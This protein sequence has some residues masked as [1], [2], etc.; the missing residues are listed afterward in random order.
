MNKQ[1]VTQ[2]AWPG[3]LAVVMGIYVYWATQNPLISSRPSVVSKYGVPDPVSSPGVNTLHSRIW[4]DPLRPAY[5]HWKQLPHGEREERYKGVLDDAANQVCQRAL[6]SPIMSVFHERGITPGSGPARQ[7][8]DMRD[9]YASLVKQGSLLCLAVYVPGEPYAEDQERRTRF[10]YAVESALADSEYRLEYSRR[11]SYI[12]PKVYIRAPGGWQER[13]IV[14]PLKLY[15]SGSSPP[16]NPKHILVLWIN[17]TEIGQRPLLALHRILH[18]IFC[19]IEPKYWQQQ[20]DVAI[21]GPDGSDVLAAMDKELEKEVDKK[22]DVRPKVCNAD[23]WKIAK[24]D[25]NDNLQHGFSPLTD[26]A[27]IRPTPIFAPAA[28]ATLELDNL[29]AATDFKLFRVIGTDEMLIEKLRDE[30]QERQAFSGKVVLITESDT[31][32]GQ[33]FVEK[34]P[35]VLQSDDQNSTALVISKDQLLTFTM[36]RG[37]DGKVPGDDGDPKPPMPVT[38]LEP[39]GLELPTD[40]TE[41]RPEGRSQFDYLRRLG[42]QIRDRVQYERVSAIGVVSTD[43]YDKLLV[44]RALRP[45]FPDAVYFTTDMDAIYT[46]PNERPYTRGLVVASHFGLSLTEELQRHAPQFRDSYQTSTFLATRLAIRNATRNLSQGAANC[47]S[48]DQGIALLDRWL[49]DYQPKENQIPALSYIVGRRSVRRLSDTAANGA[50]FHASQ[51]PKPTGGHLSLA[52]F[53]AFAM[54]VCVIGLTCSGTKLPHTGHA[55][56]QLTSQSGSPLVVGAC[57]GLLAAGFLLFVVVLA[58]SYF[59][60]ELV[61]PLGAHSTWT[62]NLLYVL[63]GIVAAA[64]L[65]Y[66]SLLAPIQYAAALQASPWQDI[67]CQLL[68]DPRSAQQPAQLTPGRFQPLLYGGL[69]AGVTGVAACAILFFGFTWQFTWVGVSSAFLIAGV[70]L[71]VGSGSS[72]TQPAA[73]LRHNPILANTARVATAWG[74]CALLAIAATV[75]LAS[76]VLGAPEPGW[77]PVSLS[78]GTAAR[79]L[80]WLS[81]SY[82]AITIGLLW[83]VTL[84]LHIWCAA[85]MSLLDHPTWPLELDRM[86]LAATLTDMP[87]R[88]VPA[89]FALLIVIM[90]GYHPLIS[91][92]PMPTSVLVLSSLALLALLAT[93]WWLRYHFHRERDRALHDLRD[94]IAAAPQPQADSLHKVETQLKLLSEGAFQP[95]NLTPFGWLLGGGTLLALVDWWIR[96]MTLAS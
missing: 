45:Q 86:R 38:K 7:R 48:G 60:P 82:A 57:Y 62:G 55:L 6:R 87:L 92:A 91:P 89:V 41:R 52:L 72:A 1:N 4:E 83:G 64:F 43:V 10:R 67:A 9:R 14:V 63:A 85:F 66:V 2:L 29:W 73:L 70:M 50:A 59:E 80:D 18:A 8:R 40:L 90:L 69:V 15:R 25:G 77:A 61:S 54:A 24:Y 36:L 19:K 3:V 35:K 16:A 17:Q 68:N 71:V 21:V 32:Y 74:I 30:L 28:T 27:E 33:V 53:V 11:L 75:F 79:T 93:T 39:A 37:I 56:R 31:R 84:Q 42:Q 78:R 96:A 5:E 49:R 81:A 12:V 76:Q 88:L 20:F 22:T 13:E 95:W 65:L 47:D 34:F 23:H 94:P 44:L 46:D 58:R 26:L 51:Q